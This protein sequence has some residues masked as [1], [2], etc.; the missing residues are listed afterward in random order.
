MSGQHGRNKR[1]SH[2]H[3]GRRAHKKSKIQEIDF[4]N[5]KRNPDSTQDL[6]RYATLADS[7]SLDQHAFAR[8]AE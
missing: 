5:P 6:V 1:G 4:S 3:R 8:V 2:A 7:E